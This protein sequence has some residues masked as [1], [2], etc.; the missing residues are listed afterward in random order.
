[1]DDIRTPLTAYNIVLVHLEKPWI[2]TVQTLG[3]DIVAALTKING[4]PWNK[5]NGERYIPGYMYSGPGA[6]LDL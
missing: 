4:V 1:M 5:Y 3:S 2:S 6:R